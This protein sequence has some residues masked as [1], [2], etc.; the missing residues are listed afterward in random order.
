MC[1]KKY[2]VPVGKNQ[3]HKVELKVFTSIFHNLSDIHE[4]LSVSAY[5]RHPYETVILHTMNS[6]IKVAKA[7]ELAGMCILEKKKNAWSTPFT[8]L[9]TYFARAYRIRYGKNSPW[10]L[11][12]HNNS[13]QA[14]ISKETHLTFKL[15][16]P[17]QLFLKFLRMVNIL[18]EEEKHFNWQL[19]SLD[20]WLSRIR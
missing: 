2:L 20:F 6:P 7:W 19:N 13:R 4:G 15:V 10:Y 3:V 17:L 11:V 14:R 8:F 9:H 5:S 12:K 18:W 1:V 16:Y